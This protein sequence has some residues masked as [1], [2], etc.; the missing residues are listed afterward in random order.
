MWITTPQHDSSLV[1]T[2][3]AFHL[4]FLFSVYFLFIIAHPASAVFVQPPP[5][6]SF[7]LFPSA[8]AD[9]I[10]HFP[11]MARSI[12]QASSLCVPFF[13]SR[14]SF[15]LHLFSSPPQMNSRARPPPTTPLPPPPPLLCGLWVVRHGWGLYIFF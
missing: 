8:I 15:S 1:P 12:R 4:R 7:F 13:F 10:C 14:L 3:A 6:L 11:P 2:S 5:P 9:L